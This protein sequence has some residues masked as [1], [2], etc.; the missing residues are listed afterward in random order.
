MGGRGGGLF[1][2]GRQGHRAS[3]RRH[4]VST[5]IFLQKIQEKKELR[6]RK[7]LKAAEKSQIK[8][9]NN[10]C[11]QKGF[12]YSSMCVSMC[13]CLCLCVTIR[14]SIRVGVNCSAI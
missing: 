8:Y 12:A 5:M 7:N 3:D 2:G 9:F 1:E 6:I 14:M 11:E 10:G 13:V 4:R